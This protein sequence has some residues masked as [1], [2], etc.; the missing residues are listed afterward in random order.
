[1]SYKMSK[2]AGKST[3]C[4]TPGGANK[5]NANTK[6][7]HYWPHISTIDGQ[8]IF[9]TFGVSNVESVSMSWRQHGD[10]KVRSV[11]SI[12]KVPSMQKALT[13]RGP[14]KKQC[15]LYWNYTQWSYDIVKWTLGNPLHMTSAWQLF[16]PRTTFVICQSLPLALFSTGTEND[17][18][19]SWGKQQALF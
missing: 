4:S 9:L 1:M 3:A 11:K 8:W 18:C 6:A 17:R 16:S 2:F 19:D 13:R 10:V 14:S 12:H 7:T 5:N 15:N